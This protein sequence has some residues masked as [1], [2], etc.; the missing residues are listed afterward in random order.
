[1]DKG[2]A[3][4]KDSVQV[5]KPISAFLRCS[6]KPIQARLRN[7]NALGHKKANASGIPAIVDQQFEVATQILGAG[8]G[9][10][11]EPEIDI[12]CPDKAQ[13]KDLLKVASSKALT[14]CQQIKS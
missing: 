5:M 2:L 11:V 8:L 1:V 4:E 10:I 14:I 6:T 9:P 7:K 3:D 12:D 13:A